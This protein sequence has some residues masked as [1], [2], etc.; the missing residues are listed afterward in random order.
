MDAAARLADVS[1][2]YVSQVLSAT[3]RFTP[4]S[5]LGRRLLARRADVLRIV[6]SYGADNVVVFGS[7]ASGTD[8]AGSDVDLMVDI[9]PGMG[10]FTLGRMEQELR[11]VLGVDV[12]VIPARLAKPQVLASAGRVAVPL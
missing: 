7:V 5:P 3:P 10:L 6:R 12:D 4:R 2:P 9:P 11:E 1:Q 8:E